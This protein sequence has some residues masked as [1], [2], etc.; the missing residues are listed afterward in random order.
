MK[1]PSKISPPTTVLIDLARKDCFL[2]SKLDH[3]LLTSQ[4]CARLV[5]WHINSKLRQSYT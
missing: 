4:D 1:A 2:K 3:V 5:V